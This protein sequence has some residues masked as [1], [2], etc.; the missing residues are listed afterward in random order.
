MDRFLFK[1]WLDYPDPENEVEILRRQLEGSV[2]EVEAITDPE[3]IMEMQEIVNHVYIDEV[4]L[5]YIRDLVQKTRSDP[6][7]LMGAGPRASLV[8][9]KCSKARAAILGRS[10]VTPDDI[11]DLIVPTLNHRLII[12]PEMENGIA[13]FTGC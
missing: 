13:I 10:Y 8:L 9:M 1:L 5:N 2:A 7:I 11:R 4:I 12:K 6:Q 3:E